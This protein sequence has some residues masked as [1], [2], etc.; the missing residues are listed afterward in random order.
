MDC[1]IESSMPM[2]E[3]S[4]DLHP[5][6]PATGPLLLANPT[7]TPN[8]APT[9][10]TRSIGSKP[11]GLKLGHPREPSHSVPHMQTWELWPT[12]K[13]LAQFLKVLIIE[14]FIYLSFVGGIIVVSM[15]LWWQWRQFDLLGVD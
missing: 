6:N 14:L 5:T 12:G 7:R 2:S 13:C 9:T 4:T 10:H 8:T 1:I 3:M 11:S 15:Q